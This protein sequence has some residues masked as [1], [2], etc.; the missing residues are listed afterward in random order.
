M[1]KSLFILALSIQIVNGAAGQNPEAKRT[2]IWY[3][4][5]GA[6][7][8]FSNG[9]PVAITD[10]A[11]HSY[12]G[13]GSICD[14]D[15]NL[16]FYTDG[17]TVWTK[18][19][20]PMPNG[21]GLAGCG[22]YGSSAQSGLILPKPGSGT[23]YYIFTN[24]C[25]EN[26]GEAGLNYSVVDMS[27]N[28]GNGDVIE[29]NILML[30]PATEALDATRHGN[31]TDFWV[32]GHEYNTNRFFA[33][34]LGE[35]GISTETVISEI[36]PLLN[37]YIAA[38]R[39]SNAGDKLAMAFNDITGND[40]LFQFD[41]STGELFGLLNLNGFAV[42]VA[43]GSAY[44]VA[45]SP[46]DTKI[47]YMRSG[48]YVYQF[49]LG[50]E[51]NEQVISATAIVV[52]YHIDNSAYR[53]FQLG[54]DNKIYIASQS[55]DSIS[56]IEFPNQYGPDCNLQP[57]N[58]YLGGRQSQT[59]LTN[60]TNSFLYQPSMSPE[61]CDTIVST[62][63]GAVSDEILI[64]PNPC[65]SEVQIAF[66]K[67]KEGQLTIYNSLGQKTKESSFSGR[68]ITVDLAGHATGIYHLIIETNEKKQR[69]KTIIIQN[70]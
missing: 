12:E 1:K 54:L 5:N 28:D 43:S 23:L 61:D 33:F 68:Q 60:F 69:K 13:G 15:G 18:L 52:D 66:S 35:N 24:D 9:S 45:F 49:C 65:Y 32:M 57:R 63:D 38:I 11:L 7:L 14:L 6:G 17:D 36:G 62:G 39:F 41:T 53:Q 21:T 25:G 40:P 55:S 47:Y 22:N 67:H 16:L 2:N 56:T 48:N 42:E 10:G 27:L 29:K 34:L 37:D 30:Y 58:F 64:F 3:F 20:Q 51:L 59:G 31:G 19:H 50:G 46:D 26:L 8:D 4:G 44:T 70:K